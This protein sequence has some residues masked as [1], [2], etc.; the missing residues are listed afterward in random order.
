MSETEGLPLR[1]VYYKLAMYGGEGLD[2]GVRVTENDI[3]EAER[4]TW[5]GDIPATLHYR[6]IAELLLERFRD[7]IR[8]S[9]EEHR[10]GGPYVPE[11]WEVQRGKELDKAIRRIADSARLSHKLG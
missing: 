5:R 8:A 4:A 7:K 2:T 1:V 10:P 9:V 3:S 6:L 11:K